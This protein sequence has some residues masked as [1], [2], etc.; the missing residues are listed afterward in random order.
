[1]QSD[2]LRYDDLR[3]IKGSEEVIRNEKWRTD[4]PPEYEAALYPG[5]Y[6]QPPESKHNLG[7]GFRKSEQ[8]RGVDCRKPDKFFPT[9]AGRMSSFLVVR[10]WR[11]EGKTL[12]ILSGNREAYNPPRS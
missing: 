8:I 4:S 3:Y 9:D 5:H 1:M 7:R 10:I 12:S 11:Y 6:R 2:D